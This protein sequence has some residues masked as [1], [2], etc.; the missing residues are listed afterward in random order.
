MRAHR[1]LAGVIA[2]CGVLACTMPVRAQEYNEFNALY[3]A[4]ITYV[5]LDDPHTRGDVYQDIIH[6]V[7]NEWAIGPRSEHGNYNAKVVNWTKNRYNIDG[8]QQSGGDYVAVITFQL[9]NTATAAGFRLI[10]PDVTGAS[11]VS[12]PLDFVL[13]DFDILGSQTGKAGSWQVL[14]EARDLRVGSDVQY[15]Y[16]DSETA[17]GIPYWEYEA[18]FD[19]E[20]TV[21]YV[22][23]AIHKLNVEKN[24][25]GTYMNL[26]EVQIFT[27]ERYANVSPDTADTST[28]GTPVTPREPLTV[29]DLIPETPMGWMIVSAVL[30]T[31]CAVGCMAWSHKKE[32]ES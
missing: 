24:P 6:L 30:A 32:K 27:P 10:H 7:D 14:Y 17:D 8:I 2:L 11:G 18:K 16:C 22:A 26:H 12:D 15:L 3:G 19:A 20:T 1:M 5:G 28:P 4:E 23:L 13:S 9:A 25:M 29:Q 31:G 21:S